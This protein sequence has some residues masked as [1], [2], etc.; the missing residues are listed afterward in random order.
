LLEILTDTLHRLQRGRVVGGQRHRVRLADHLKL[1]DDDVHDAGHRQPTQQD[2]HREQADEAGDHRVRAD[3][4]VAHADFTK[5]KVW[6]FKPSE[7]L[8]SLT[9]PSTVMRQ[10]MVSPSLWAMMFGL[11][12]GAV[13]VSVSVH[14][15]GVFSAFCG[16]ESRS[17]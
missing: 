15:K 10:V 17:R 8:S 11:A 1:R 5:Q 9:T 4:C 3:V 16:C 6:A 13:V 2:W 12:A 14:G 7:V